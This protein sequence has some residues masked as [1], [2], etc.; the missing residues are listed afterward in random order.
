MFRDSYVLCIYVMNILC[1][2]HTYPGIW[3]WYNQTK[4]YIWVG[5]VVQ[6]Q[7]Y[8]SYKLHRY[9]SCTW[10]RN[11]DRKCLR[12]R[13]RERERESKRERES[14]SVCVCG[15]VCVVERACMY[16]QDHSDNLSNLSIDRRRDGFMPLFLFEGVLNLCRGC[17]L[18]PANGMSD[19]GSRQNVCSKT[20]PNHKKGKFK[21]VHW[22]LYIIHASMYFQTWLLIVCFSLL[23]IPL[24]FIIFLPVQFIRVEYGS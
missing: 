10:Y 24:V 21:P 8:F 7:I 16:L 9:Q 13:E 11:G 5:G 14:L 1:T 2:F 23:L 15:C 6:I 19:N 12:E 4:P 22:L 17:S 18:G 20:K 3:L